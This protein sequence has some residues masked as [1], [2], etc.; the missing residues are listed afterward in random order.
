MQLGLFGKE[1]PKTVQ[2]FEALC[3][4][5]QGFGYKGSV[6]HRVIRHFMA[7]GGDMTTGDGRGGKSIYGEKFEDE[8]FK[9]KHFKGAL[10]MAN[11][12]PNTNGSQFFITFTKTSH[13]DGHHVVFGALVAGQD[14]LDQ[15]EVNPTGPHDRPTKTV[16]IEQCVVEKIK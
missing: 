2:N 1:V 8:N 4:G 7:Q 12:G 11:A 3:S 9:I 14:V 15:I 16:R 10:S 5:E 6:F 13:L